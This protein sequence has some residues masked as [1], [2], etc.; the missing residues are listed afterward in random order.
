[1][2]GKVVASEDIPAATQ[3]FTPKWIVQLPR[4]EHARSAMA[5]DLPAVAAAG[6]R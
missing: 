6:A 2:I 4:P 1:M 3:L 5:G